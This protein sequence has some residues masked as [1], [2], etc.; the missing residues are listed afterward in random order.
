MLRVA[1]GELERVKLDVHGLDLEHRALVLLRARQMHGRSE[2]LAA[3]EHVRETRVAQLREAGL[4]AEPEGDVAHVRLDLAERE[5]ELVVLLVL[6]GLVGREL[7]EV[8]RLERDDVREEVPAGERQV[9]DDEVHLIVGVLDARNG[10]VADLK[11][12]I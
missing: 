7:E 12:V 3:E 5:R 10:D 4:L 1:D 2:A 11:R 9:L 8:V 6:D